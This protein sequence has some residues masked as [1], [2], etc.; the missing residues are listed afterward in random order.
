MDECGWVEILLPAQSL[1][2]GDLG[3]GRGLRRRRRGGRRR[4]EARRKR[5]AE[6]V[7]E[8]RMKPGAFW[9]MIYEFGRKT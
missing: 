6:I 5:I 2:T 8:G 4:Y 9:K 7:R 1:T 3:I